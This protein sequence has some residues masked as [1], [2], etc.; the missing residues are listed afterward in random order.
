MAL[1]K[2]RVSFRDYCPNT[3]HAIRK[4]FKQDD[5]M[6]TTSLSR[7]RNAKFKLGGR[8][9][10]LLLFSNDSRYVVKQID[11]EEYN[12][13]RRA[14]PPR[15]PSPLLHAPRVSPPGAPTT[16]TPRTPPL[17]ESRLMR[18]CSR[19]ATVRTRAGDAH[20]AGV[21]ALPRAPAQHHD[22]ARLPAVLL[23]DVRTP[24]AAHARARA[25]LVPGAIPGALSLYP[26]PYPERCPCTR[27]HRR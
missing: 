11:W 19:A 7:H 1:K 18:T 27:R 12:N 22:P 20:A 21:L 26:A 4:A 3:F 23:R 16:A 13:A 10:S 15:R 25:S 24:P 2:S 6:Y 8:S 17:R 14:L 5:D 9:G